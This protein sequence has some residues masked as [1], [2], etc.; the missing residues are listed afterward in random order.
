MEDAKGFFAKVIAFFKSRFFHGEIKDPTGKQQEDARK[1][2]YVE[3]N[4]TL[5]YLNMVSMI[6]IL[7]NYTDESGNTDI[8][9]RYR[10]I[11]EVLESLYEQGDRI[12]INDVM[13]YI[14]QADK[15]IHVVFNDNQDIFRALH[16]LELFD[17]PLLEQG[18]KL[19]TTK[20]D[21]VKAFNT[22]DE[23]EYSKK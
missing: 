5:Y 2:A 4:E 3:F 18:M 14:E 23:G 17:A 13:S 9:N 12:S 16:V 8:E 21:I 11:G 20:D 22:K 19:F 7:K 1:L 10:K 6:E 15:D